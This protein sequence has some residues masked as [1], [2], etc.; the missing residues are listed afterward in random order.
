VS[1]T[2][3]AIDET[4][5]SADLFADD[6]QFDEAKRTFR[7]ELVPAIEP[8]RG[9]I[10]ESATNLAD[11]LTAICRAQ[12]LLR[13][14]QCYAS[15]KSDVDTRNAKL[16]A[17]RQETQLLAAEFAQ[18]VSFVRPEILAADADTLAS[19]LTL[20]PRLAE[21][22][23]DLH[24]LVR[25]RDRVLSP[26]E[27]KIVAETSLLRSEPASMYQT[28]ADADLP[29]PDMVLA[30]GTSVTL[31]PA[32][33]HKH[34]QTT[35][36]P[37]RLAMFPAYFGAYAAFRQTLG[38]NLYAATK[39]HIFK[40]R[41]RGY[42]SC[43]HAALDS[44]NVPERVYRNLIAQVRE[45]LPALHRYVRLRARAL[46]VERLEYP[47]L[48]CPLVAATGRKYTIAEARAAVLDGMQPLG[49]AYGSILDSAFRS[50]WIDWHPTHGKRS[51]AYSNGS[52]YG[53]HPYVLMNF[54]EDHDTVMTLAHEMGHAL[55]S[56]FSNRAQPFSTASYSIFVAEVASTFNETLLRRRMFER[57]ETDDERIFLLT[58]HLDGLRGTLF[59]QTMFAEFELEIHERA[60]RGEALTGEKLS[61]IYLRIL[62][63]YHG[64]DEGVM[65]IDERY[66]VEWA[67]I[68]HFYYDFY[69]YQYATGIVAA[70]SLADG[71]LERR[72]GAHARYLTFLSS[73]GSNYPLELLRAAGVDLE[74]PDAYRAT[75]DSID[76]TLDSLEQALA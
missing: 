60:E 58:S 54:N 51:G 27:E 43:L 1:T 5:N 59:R 36:R 29:R 69:V 17:M 6:G 16:Q 75:F 52:A 39:A 28:L 55:H 61:E 42:R 30:D 15:L 32:K 72:E 37:D 66:A 41:V 9:K 63:D 19:F 22:A 25:Q 18:R 48:Y 68:P 21:F 10:A 3:P 50:R 65:E 33:F 57:A 46:G 8:F 56:F 38:Q 12:E 24:D 49:E 20:E 14:V 73:G 11:G 44:D 2:A 70:T 64:H 67:A 53:V 35:H 71:V 4:W 34:R 7:D 31:T 23:H 45:R 47:D 26:A 76:R 13:R 62:R 40:S 74:R